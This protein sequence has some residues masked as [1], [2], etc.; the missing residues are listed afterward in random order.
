M[1]KR[2]K[3][4]KDIIQSIYKKSVDGSIRDK[5]G[6]DRE[7]TEPDT[8][9]EGSLGS[10]MRTKHMSEK[11]TPQDDGGGDGLEDYVPAKKAQ[12]IQWNL[13]PGA[14][15]SEGWSFGKEFAK[16]SF[17]ND[18][19]PFSMSQGSQNGSKKSSVVGGA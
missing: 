8:Y 2:L 12:S 18:P 6:S 3:Y 13:T 5:T 16:K 7:P 1:V 11:K 4:A 10:T 14:P 17:Q 15:P 19:I 9:Y